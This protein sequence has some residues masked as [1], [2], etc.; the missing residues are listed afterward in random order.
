MLSIARLR[1]EF[2]PGVDV[3]NIDE[4]TIQNGSFTAILG[5]SGC[6]KSTLLRILAGLVAPTSGHINYHDRPLPLRPG[7]AAFMAQDDSLLPWRRA[8]DNAVLGAEVQ[9]HD[10]DHLRNRAR[11][12]FEQFG[13]T[14]HENKWPRE[15][16]GGMRQRV[17]LLRT[18]LVQTD[19]L[20]LDEPFGA[21]DSLT[22]ETMQSWLRD[23]LCVEPRT[24]ILVTHDIEEALLL[25]DQIVVLGSAPARKVAEHSV[26][27]RYKSKEETLTDTSFLAERIALHQLLRQA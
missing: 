16:S 24:V 10:V 6:G 14:G 11:T 18:F 23:V 7:F 20:L 5:P 22:R 1:H 25:A 4:L 2:A 19:L 12:M 15:L 21:L 3:L 26:A 17:A 13:L 8:I 27:F 9:G